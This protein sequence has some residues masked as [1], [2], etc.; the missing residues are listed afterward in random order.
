M[1]HA[2]LRRGPPARRGGARRALAMGTTALVALAV[3][4]CGGCAFSGNPAEDKPDQGPSVAVTAPAAPNAVGR[5]SAVAAATINGSGSAA[6]TA[7]ERRPNTSLDMATVHLAI[8][9]ALMAVTGTHRP[10]ALAPQP[11]QAG[12]SEQAA[13]AAAAYR[14]LA[15]LFPNR[16]AHFQAAYD[17]SLAGIGEGDAK[18]RGLALGES[19]AAAVLRRRQNDNRSVTP[20][21]Y[22]SGTEAGQFRTANPAALVNHYLPHVR[23][24]VLQQAAQFRPAGPPA[25]ASE[26]YAASFNETRSLGA[27]ASSTRSAG[28]TDTARF[29]T[30]PP[31]RFWTRNL[32]PFASQPA[33]LG[34]SAR[35]MALLWVAHADATIACFE[36]KYHYKAWRPLSAIPMANDDGNA[37]TEPDAAWAPVV[38]TP[39]H[40]EYPAA[41]SCAAAAVAEALRSFYGTRQ[42]RFGFDSQVAGLADGR[43]GYASTTAM[44]EE[45]QL[46]RIWGG[47]HFRYATEDGATLGRQVA[48]W[49]ATQQFQPR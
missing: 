39:N 20:Q 19:A 11:P 2:E 26:A 42:V 14:V 18:A 6:V 12:A 37:A 32:L 1:I 35:L 43:R 31:P 8:Y 21:P 45:L 30:E 38:P 36:A 3:A 17:H 44:V 23:P 33:T 41:H 48:R 34:E 47:M 4:A 28:Q 13:V 27:A 46:A 22:L 16:T 29:H 7:E 49:V 5:W 9:D 25:L 40:P 15:A 24:F 10:F